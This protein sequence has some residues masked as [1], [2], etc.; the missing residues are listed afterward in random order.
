MPTD[1]LIVIACV[2]APFV[3]FACVLAYQDYACSGR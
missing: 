2:A 1:T 3:L